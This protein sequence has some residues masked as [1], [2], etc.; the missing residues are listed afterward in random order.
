MGGEGVC[1]GGKRGV[2]GQVE[3][4]GS[5][6]Y[7]DVSTEKLE[8]WRACL[9]KDASWG[10]P[11]GFLPPWCPLPTWGNSPSPKAFGRLPTAQTHS[12]LYE[13]VSRGEGGVVGSCRVGGEGV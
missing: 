12:T 9:L 13:L 7:L 2:Y 10:A 11:G 3:G 1:G 6:L 8:R 5:K 4:G